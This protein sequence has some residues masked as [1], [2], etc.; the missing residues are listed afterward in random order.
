MGAGPIWLG[1]VAVDDVNDLCAKIKAAGGRVF[2]EPT[3]VPGMLRFAV[4]ADP[5]L[6]TFM[7][8]KGSAKPPD[9][10]PAPARPVPSAGANCM[11]ARSTARG[12]FIPAYL[13]GRRAIRWIWALTTNISCFK[14]D[15]VQSGGMMTKMAKT[16]APFWLYYFNVPKL[17][18]CVEAIK[19]NDAQ[20]VNGP[21]QVP[22]GQWIVHAVDPQG[23]MFA[24]VAN[25]R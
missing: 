9:E 13:V 8:M 12:R 21:M 25:A 5:Y 1:Y 23:A 20:I 15:G 10:M 24:L 6:A 22:G 2:K 18:P 14:I 7:I 4:V 3:D 17:D 19:A 16:P 11:R